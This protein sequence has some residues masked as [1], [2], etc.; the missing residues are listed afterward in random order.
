LQN[1]ETFGRSRTKTMDFQTFQDKLLRKEP[2]NDQN[3]YI[4]NFS[5]FQKASPQSSQPWGQPTS[6]QEK[7]APSSTLNP[8]APTMLLL[9]PSKLSVLSSNLPVLSSNPPVL[10]SNPPVLSCRTSRNSC[11]VAAHL[12][13]IS[14]PIPVLVG[15]SPD[16]QLSKSRTKSQRKKS[17]RPFY[18]A[19]KLTIK[20]E[21]N[22]KE[23]LPCK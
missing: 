12:P 22:A 13:E 14:V 4:Q 9:P 16:S 7:E 18:D 21:S 23:E 3:N 6:S 20:K 8:K 1:Y 17:D 2:R 5:A 10:S 11:I 15:Y 19:S